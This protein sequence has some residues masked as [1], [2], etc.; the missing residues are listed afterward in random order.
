MTPQSISVII[1]TYNNPEWLEKTLWGYENQNFKDFDIMIADDGSKEATA[2]LIKKFQTETK[3]S[4]KHIWHPDNGFQKCEILNQA[5]LA[6][7]A[8][9]LIF[10]DHDCIPRVD[11]VER[12]RKYAED[13][14]FLS[15]GYFKLPM[16]I[17]KAIGRNDILTGDAF[18]PKWLH[19]QG[20]KTTFKETKLWHVPVY[21]SILNFITPARASWNG[22]NSSCWRKDALLV[23]GFNTEMKYGGLDREFGERL[24]NAGLKS[25]QLRYSLIAIHL[26]HERPYKTK[27]QLAANLQI[28][29]NVRKK[30]VV[31]TPTGIENLDKA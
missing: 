11:F 23:N 18:D 28:R 9:Y 17:S 29:K 15:G 14:Y 2:T 21:A 3:L 5:I 6:S 30:K 13:G 26:D 16:S 31:K 7:D 22:C 27:E 8:E 19:Q 10:T 12:H 4:I 1:S 20:M 25:K 24:V